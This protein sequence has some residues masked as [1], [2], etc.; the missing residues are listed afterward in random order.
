[1]PDRTAETQTRGR[2]PG[3]AASA[4]TTAANACSRVAPVTPHPILGLQRAAGNRATAGLL[5]RFPDATDIDSFWS[6]LADQVAAENRMM[7]DIDCRAASNR[8]AGIGRSKAKQRRI[9]ANRSPLKGPLYRIS[10]ADLDATPMEA[11]EAHGRGWRVRDRVVSFSGRD[12]IAKQR[13]RLAPGQAAL[14]PLTQDGQLPLLL[15]SRLLGHGVGERLEATCDLAQRGGNLGSTAHP[16]ILYS[17]PARR[18]TTTPPKIRAIPSARSAVAGSPR[19]STPT[20]A[21]PIVPMPVQ[22]A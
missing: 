6:Q 1:M 15:R 3:G 5:Q 12:Y 18:R 16:V 20:R 19:A 9:K 4:A 22:T 8:L 17:T 11:T 13:A 10:S 2:H 14:A 21:A 7:E